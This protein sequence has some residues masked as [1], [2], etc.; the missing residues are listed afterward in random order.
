MTFRIVWSDAEIQWLLTSPEGPVGELIGELSEK[1]AAVARGAVHVRPGTA[2]S[3][4]TGH[5][6]NARPPGFTKADIRVHGPVRGAYGMYGGV[7]AAADPTIFLE[8]PAR[9][10]DRRYPFLTVGLDS[11]DL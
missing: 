1:A 7:N 5:G 8:L 9:Q 10:M 6:S 3:A 2:K 4:T 11:L